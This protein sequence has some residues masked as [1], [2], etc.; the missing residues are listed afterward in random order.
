[1]LQTRVRRLGA[2]HILSLPLL[3]LDQLC[4]DALSRLAKLPAPGFLPLLFQP[5]LFQRGPERLQLSIQ[6]VHTTDGFVL[7]LANP[8]KIA[9]TMFACRPSLLR[10]HLGLGETLLKALHALIHL[11]YASPNGLQR[12]FLS[13][14]F[15]DPLL[16]LCLT[17]SGFLL[18]P[19]HFQRTALRVTHQRLDPLA[20]ISK[21]ML[22][23]RRIFLQRQGLH[24]FIP[25]GL[26]HTTSF[27]AKRSE[28]TR[29]N[30]SHMSISYA[31]FCL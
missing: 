23:A 9:L 31:V 27:L 8:L 10:G 18:Q 13:G 5:T 14:F 17:G 3:R 2:S 12:A 29:L 15:C 26:G 20:E 19:L 25:Q 21:K 16:Q 24:L 1:M 6:A 7:F 4:F 28:S 22:Q 30:S 11:L